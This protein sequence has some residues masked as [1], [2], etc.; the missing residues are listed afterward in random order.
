MY[1]QGEHGEKI[2]IKVLV[3]LMIAKP[4]SHKYQRKAVNLSY[5]RGMKLAHPV[6]NDDN[7][8]FEI[9]LLIGADFY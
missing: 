3:V 7:F 2:P 1:V 4:L 6:S 8:E 9:S 5:L